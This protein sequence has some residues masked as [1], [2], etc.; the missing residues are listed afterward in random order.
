MKENRALPSYTLS[1]SE[2][3]QES[4]IEEKVKPAGK[5]E[6]KGGEQ[7]DSNVDQD[8]RWNTAVDR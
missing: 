6:D 7:D 8:G 1:L 2:L 5:E 4:Q 3:Q